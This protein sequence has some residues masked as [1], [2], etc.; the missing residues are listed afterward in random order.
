[1]QDLFA[2]EE[3]EGLLVL[4]KERYADLTDRN[5]TLIGLLIY[6]GLRPEELG[7]LET[8][9]INLEAGRIYVRETA[10]THGRLL[11]LKPQQVLLLLRYLQ[12][13]RTRLLKG[14]RSN[15]LLIGQRGAPMSAEDIT[16]HVKRRY[17]G[18]YAPRIVNCRT[19][20]QSVIANLLAL[21]MIFVWCSLLRV[22]GIHRARKSTAR[23]MFRPYRQ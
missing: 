13:V 15:Y 21:S 16:R 1:L 18:V 5:R 22:I 19:I 20:R 17:G 6:Q 23:A 9:C 10:K 7:S 2:A 12:D 11:A 3:L 4:R 8:G 14:R